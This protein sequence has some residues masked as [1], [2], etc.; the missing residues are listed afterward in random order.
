[1]ALCFNAVND[2]LEVYWSMERVIKYRVHLAYFRFPRCR[3]P[4]LRELLEEIMLEKAWFSWSPW[5][6]ALVCGKCS[7]EVHVKCSSAIKG[8]QILVSAVDTHIRDVHSWS[9]KPHPV[10]PDRWDHLDHI[11]LVS[12]KLLQQWF[13]GRKIQIFSTSANGR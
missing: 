6:I 10:Q 13:E 3:Y 2:L 12:P 11:S 9:D 8:A 1:M 4:H 5:D 7:L